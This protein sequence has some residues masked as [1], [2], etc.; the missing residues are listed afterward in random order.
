M[1]GLA[2]S[3]EYVGLSL[4]VFSEKYFYKQRRDC[5]RISI[6]KKELV[7][8]LVKQSWKNGVFI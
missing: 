6:Y 5:I 8:T 2:V 7:K 3:E 4:V 1:F